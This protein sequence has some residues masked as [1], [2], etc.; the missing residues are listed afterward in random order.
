M[1][2]VDNERSKYINEQSLR[3]L[4]YWLGCV[5]HSELEREEL[6]EE[7]MEVESATQ[8]D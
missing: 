8:S 6:L 4:M 1:E 7:Y 5:C 2:L 3:Y